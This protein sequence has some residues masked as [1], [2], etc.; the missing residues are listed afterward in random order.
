[1]ST[2]YI[3]ADG[4]ID[5]ST[6]L[7][8][9]YGDVYSL[10]GDIN[11]ET[12][13]IVIKRD[14]I[15]LDGAGH[16][17]QGSNAFTSVGIFLSGRR[18]VSIRNLQIQG[19]DHGIELDSSCNNEIVGNNVTGISNYGLW[20]RYSSDNNSIVGN[21]LRCGGIANIYLSTSSS[22][23]T[24]FGNNLTTSDIG[25][26]LYHSAANNSITG[27]RIT[28][29]RAMAM[30][31]GDGSDCNRICGDYLANN[32]YG[33]Y[34]DESMRN[35]IFENEITANEE[36]ICLVIDSNENTIYGNNITDHSQGIVVSASSN[37]LIYHNNFVNN[38]RHAFI[39]YNVNLWDDGY[40]SGGNYWSN[41][42]G[43]DLYSGVYQNETGRDGIGDTAY[44]VNA[45]NAD[46]YPLMDLWPDSDF[47]LLNVSP[48]KTVVG[49]GYSTKFRVTVENQKDYEG[50]AEVV[51][52]ANG[53]AVA[54]GSII[55]PQR[56]SMS[57]D[58]TWNTTGIAL[59][60]YAV[61][62]CVEPAPR[63]LDL[64]DNV[65]TDGTV[66]VGTPGDV[67]GD[68]IVNMVDLYLIAS[69]YGATDGEARYVSNYDV[70]G[71][72][73]TNMVDMYIAGTHFGTSN[74]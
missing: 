1:M 5:P 26:V 2:I 68:A 60:N 66:Y 54:S 37:N 43:T 15:T 10:V 38:T 56:S 49:Q 59:G 27:N 62:V 70:D 48:S 17:L 57:V 9:H 39:E 7:I 36:G 42:T 53:E 3:R 51:V 13:G 47:A 4:S 29:C 45:E 46:R 61:S 71:N 8:Q 64:S 20:I 14:N 21:D 18:N 33:A 74:P 65:L 35:V 11:S 24:V 41:Y 63:E 52:R 31:F 44:A 34:L 40:P 23:N 69:H 55:V 72:G 50:P 6:A 22:Y 73:M 67:N 12:N 58:F 28:E 25:I 19:F 16:A 32:M 30:L